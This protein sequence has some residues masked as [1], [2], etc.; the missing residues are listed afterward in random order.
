[1]RTLPG[2]ARQLS[3]LAGL[4]MMLV[5]PGSAVAQVRD[6]YNPYYYSNQTYTY[7][8]NL[9]QV[10]I[11][12]GQDEVRSADGTTCR[13]SMAGNS[14]YL[15]VGAIGSQGYG[16]EF[17]QGTFY[18]RL[19]IP[20]GEKPNRVDCTKLY[21]LEIRRLRHELELVRAGSGSMV[22]M[23]ATPQSAA[24]AP[25]SAP[26]ATTAEKPLV[27]ATKG[28][29]KSNSEATKAGSWSNSGW[30]TE[31]WQERQNLGMKVAADR[32]AT[33][34]E[35]QKKPTPAKTPATTVAADTTSGWMPVVVVHQ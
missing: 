23:V 20:L 28:T 21:E 12:N 34:I 9:P 29:K 3:A 13:S 33:P 19:I 1:M 8:M 11:P 4:V 25:G 24:S 6:N 27:P 26:A 22:P 17:D 15:D 30:S 16:G 14:A 7:G 5:A 35:K 32:R 31:G 18:G 10:P 2:Y